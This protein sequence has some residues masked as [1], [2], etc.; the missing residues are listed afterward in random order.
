MDLTLY[1]RLPTELR[2]Y[3]LGLTPKRVPLRSF[4]ELAREMD[5]TRGDPILDTWAAT[6][7]K[8]AEGPFSTSKA[9]R[10]AL[11]LWIDPLAAYLVSRKPPR[12]LEQV[13]GGLSHRQLAAMAL[14]SILDRIHAGWDT[15]AKN[16][17]GLFTLELGR[18]VR[19]ELEFAGLLAAKRW[20]KAGNK[21][22][23]L[24]KFRRVDWTNKECAR[25]GDWLWDALAELP[26][27]DE[28]ERGL[29]CIQAEHKAAIDA[30]AEAHLF[31]HPLYRPS[32]TAPDPWT[33][34]RMPRAGIETAFVAARDPETVK[35]LEAA[36]ADGSITEHARAVSSIERVPL[37]INP[38]TL[39]LVKGFAGAEYGRDTAVADALRGRVFYNL[40]RCDFRGRFTHLCDFNYTR[41]DP[42]R[43]LFMFAR[44]KPI[45]D[46]IGW[47]EVAVA[48]AY[49]VKVQER[50]EWVA[51]N[52]EM[53]RAVAADPS[54]IWRRDIK[55][56]E[57]FQFAA[58]CAEYVAADTNGPAYETRL[59]VWLDAS[60]NGLQH[61]ALMARDAK[62]A[63][64][65][66]LR[67]A[68]KPRQGLAALAPDDDQFPAD[69]YD[70]VAAHAR[71]NLLA[72]G[73]DFWLGMDLRDLLK[74]PIMTLPYGVTRAGMLDQIKE[75]CEERG[76]NAPFEALVRL[77][78]HIWRAI[79][80]KLP[81]AMKAREYIQEVTVSKYFLD[82]GGYVQWITPSGFPVANRY[83]KGKLDRVVLPFLGQKVIIA[84]G[85]T[86]EPHGQKAINAAVAN[87]VHSMEAAHLA[88][89]ANAAV[90]EGI[91]NILSIHDCYA[92]DAPSVRRFGLIR[93]RE[94]AL[95]YASYNALARLR[96]INLPGVNSLPLPEPDPDFDIL[97]VG[98]SE[99]FDR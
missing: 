37:A 59:P 6:E 7:A 20:V 26:C 78:D 30:F 93:R 32:L 81:G 25:C 8:A 73:D 89:S 9:G 23:R 91:T 47:L 60:S 41:G 97:A 74:Q 54:I 66:N 24:G 63:A 99:Y 53:I 17:A 57:P 50:H 92:T 51:R 15:E 21:H 65:V 3:A 61:L 71:C 2:F 69:V 39:P 12:G 70:I 64:M 4:Q 52:R 13:L 83:R 67:T 11:R 82:C 85:Y 5:T 38:V 27:F 44:G 49:G 62:L 16:P 45:G 84:E 79:E 29:P 56:K 36:F 94:L 1:D 34:Y 77:R 55:A 87:L 75:G 96:D 48:N 40:I 31:D 42:V 19:N 72:D 22:A 95:M 33:G 58:A 35:A 86:D 80:E 90:A 46:A 10:E 76:I 43:S 98:E 68:A 18:V 88:R 28:D 14:R